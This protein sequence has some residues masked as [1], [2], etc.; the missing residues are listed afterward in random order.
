LVGVAV[1]VNDEPAQVGLV[2]DV[3][4]IDTAGVTALLTVIVIL[5]D[6]IVAVPPPI[7]KVMFGL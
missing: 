3:S 4:A 5:F 6:E 1:K 2:P 7:V